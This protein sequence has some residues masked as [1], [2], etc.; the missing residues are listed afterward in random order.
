MHDFLWKIQNS[1]FC[2]IGSQFYV[3]LQFCQ[4][5]SF[6][7]EFSFLKI[8]IVIKKSNEIKKENL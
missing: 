7:K 1:H 8:K 5:V 2:E 6:T 4:I 3:T